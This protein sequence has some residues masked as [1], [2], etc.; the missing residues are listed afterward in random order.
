MKSSR[1]GVWIA[2]QLDRLKINHSLK[3]LLAEIISLDAKGGCF[4]SNQYLADLLN[5]KV[6][7]ISKNISELKRLG[8]VKQTKF[9]GRKR[10][11]APS[12]DFYKTKP[13]EPQKNL[14]QDGI[15][16]KESQ[17]EKEKAELEKNPSLYTLSTLY[18]ENTLKKSFD[19]F[20][21]WGKERLS[22]SSYLIL[23]SISDPEKLPK[24]LKRN[25]DM[26]VRC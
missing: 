15:K 20:K 10:F 3:R 23:E 21:N 11:L 14:T 26:F 18:L 1:T 8:L 22:R 25:Y 13:I 2:D 6:N 5:L 19:D 24:D 9:D 17:L 12:V 7:T 4:A 16:I